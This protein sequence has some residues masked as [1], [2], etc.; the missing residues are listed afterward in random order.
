MSTPVDRL[1]GE[2]VG[3]HEAEVAVGAV[4]VV[5][6]EPIV[7][8]DGRRA[9]YPRRGQETTGGD[10]QGD[11]FAGSQDR[12]GEPQEGPR[13]TRQGHVGLPDVRREGR[14]RRRSDGRPRHREDPAPPAGGPCT[15]QHGQDRRHR[16]GRLHASS[17]AP[18][19]RTVPGRQADRRS[20]TLYGLPPTFRVVRQLGRR[21]PA[22]RAGY[23]HRTSPA[24]AK[25]S[26]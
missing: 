12:R 4:A 14:D 10:D 23:H 17:S 22:H 11:R 7:H 18:S 6:E 26:A 16:S 19:R 5:V 1:P 24:Q 9:S 25:L 13:G 20:P 15:P 3:G 8:G 2:L 21:R